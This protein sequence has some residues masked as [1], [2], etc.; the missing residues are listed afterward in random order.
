MSTWG[1][2]NSLTLPQQFLL[3]KACPSCRGEGAVCP[4]K[5]TWRFQAQPTPLSRIYS[6]RLDYR[7]GDGP[8]VFVEA[9]SLEVLAAGRDLPHVYR[10]PLRLCL[11]MP[12][13]GQWAPYKRL[14]QTIVPW[15]YTWLFYF[16]DWLTF[17][18]WRGGGRHPD[19]APSRSSNR[20]LR[21]SL[22][23]ASIG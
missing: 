12:G 4:G 5:L 16:E 11:Y 17:G 8:D 18:E 2:P 1:K 7:I 3:L 23:R 9:P 10:S 21:R 15:T 6:I 22:A 13:S 14:D 20:H 19:G